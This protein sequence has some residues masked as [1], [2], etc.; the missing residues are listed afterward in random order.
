MINLSKGENV[1]LTKSTNKISVGISW[2]PS[3]SSSES[4]DL[5]VLAIGLT[6]KNGKAV[7]DEY[8]VF[9]NSIK[10]TADGKPCDPEQAI[11]HSGDNR[12]GSGDGDDEVINIDFTK[13][14]PSVNAILFVVNV[15]NET[16]NR[17][18]FGQI[19]KPRAKV[20][21]N[22]S[23]EA[24]YVYELDEDFSTAT[25]IEICSVYKHN[26]EWKVQ[27]IGEVNGNNLMEELQKVGVPSTGNA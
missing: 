9:Y 16:G 1:R 23:T 26:G 22:G 19:K 20:Y 24:S 12:T 11:I 2:D 4:A 6:E 25:T 15:Y 18:N 7:S 8:V 14:N 10:K 13:I 27:A 3:D 17:M 21:E 5:D